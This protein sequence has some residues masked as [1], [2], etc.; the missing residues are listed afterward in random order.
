MSDRLIEL[1]ILLTHLQQSVQELDEVA[2]LQSARVD[3][4]ERD[5]K[6]VQLEIGMLRDSSAEIRT[7]A[8]EKPPHY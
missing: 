4:L 3:S 2:R 6:R 8:E 5:L 7:L 1:E